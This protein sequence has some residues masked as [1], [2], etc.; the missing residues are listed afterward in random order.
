MERDVK[1]SLAVLVGFFLVALGAAAQPALTWV[2]MSDGIPEGEW[3]YPLLADGDAV[4]AADQAGGRFFR[5]PDH[6]M[7]WEEVTAP[8]F[9]PYLD[10]WIVTSDGDYLAGHAESPSDLYRSEDGGVTWV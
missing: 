1:R 10:V 5:T 4:L 2:R 8:S 6:G 7:Q 3:L 9:R